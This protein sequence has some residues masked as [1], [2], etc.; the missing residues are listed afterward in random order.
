M[1]LRS[2]STLD[3]WVEQSGI[4]PAVIKVDTETTEPA[5]LAGAMGVLKQLR[6]WVFCEVLAEGDAG[7]VITGMMQPLG[8]TFY[9]LTRAG[10]LTEEAR[11]VGDETNDHFMWLLAPE[12]LGDDHWDRSVQWARALESAD[13][14]REVVDV[15]P[16]TAPPAPTTQ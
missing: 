9:H 16:R 12:P 1:G 15:S 14:G 4:R 11:V 7:D 10:R 3:H 2:S 5:V 8:Y 13:V 6:P